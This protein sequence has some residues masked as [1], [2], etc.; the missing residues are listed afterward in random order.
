MKHDK[1]KIILQIYF[2][3]KMSKLNWIGSVA[4]AGVTLATPSETW[5]RPMHRKKK[6][7]TLRQSERKRER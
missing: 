1:K 3:G 5:E 7:K 6:E 2:F 4:G